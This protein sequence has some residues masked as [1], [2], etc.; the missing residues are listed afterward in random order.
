MILLI[1]VVKEGN[2]NA[3]KSKGAWNINSDTVK[4]ALNKSTGYLQQIIVSNLP[5]LGV[6]GE[7]I[8][9]RMQDENGRE[10][11]CFALLHYRITKYH[12]CSFSLFHLSHFVP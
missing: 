10:F 6:K 9:Q 12:L 2:N 3:S 5:H 7:I 4:Q 1:N 11:A 8:L